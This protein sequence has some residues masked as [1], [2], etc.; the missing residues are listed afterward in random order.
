[1]EDHKVY[2]KKSPEKCS[3]FKGKLNQ[4]TLS[5]RRPDGGLP[6]QRFKINYLKE[7]Q[8]MKRKC[9]KKSRKWTGHL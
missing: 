7:A 1:M 9:G 6:T 8:R 5:L 2:R 4:Q 3:L